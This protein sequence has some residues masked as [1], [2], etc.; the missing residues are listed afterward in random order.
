MMFLAIVLAVWVPALVVGA[1][2]LWSR[3]RPLRYADRVLVNL[4]T[5]NAIEGVLVQNRRGTL[6]LA[7]ASVIT[8]EGEVPVP[9]EGRAVIPAGQVDFIQELGNKP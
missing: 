9:L 8:P 3:H 4:T 5:G 1:V 6:T 7:E 2:W